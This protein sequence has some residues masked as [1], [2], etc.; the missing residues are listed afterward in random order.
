MEMKILPI[1]DGCLHSYSTIKNSTKSRKMQSDSECA[2]AGKAAFGSGT[3]NAA[4]GL[5]E[6]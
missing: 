5:P 3:P 1:A 6:N 2:R 4:R